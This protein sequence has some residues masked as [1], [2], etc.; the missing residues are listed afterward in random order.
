MGDLNEAVQG[1]LL[2][3][4]SGKSKPRQKIVTGAPIDL[5]EISGLTL[6]PPRSRKSGGPKRVNA[7]MHQRLRSFQKKKT[8]GLRLNP[9][10]KRDA[11]DADPTVASVMPCP[12]DGEP[13]VQVFLH[14]GVRAFFC[15]KCRVTQPAP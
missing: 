7:D 3:L 15:P 1:R 9:V 8:T 12:R 4:R 13:T 5:S 2:V 11:E 10:G 14:T 6:A